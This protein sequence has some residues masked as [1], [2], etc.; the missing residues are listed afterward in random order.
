MIRLLG[1]L[2]SSLRCSLFHRP[3]WEVGYWHV[4]GWTDQYR[5]VRCPSCD[6]CWL[7]VTDMGPFRP[8]EWTPVGDKA[9]T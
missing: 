2:L 5:I 7:D 9:G 3:K 1:S 8:E 4:Y 6:R